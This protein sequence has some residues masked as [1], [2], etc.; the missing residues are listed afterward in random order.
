M[1][2]PSVV[3]EVIIVRVDEDLVRVQLGVRKNFGESVGNGL[4]RATPQGPQIP[5]P[6][7]AL[8]ADPPHQVVFAREGADSRRPR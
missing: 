1:V 8:L 5:T 2:L 7:L 4:S 6:F 3:R